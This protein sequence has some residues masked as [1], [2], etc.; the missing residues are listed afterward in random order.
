MRNPAI[1]IA[2]FVAFCGMVLVNF[3]IA[4]SVTA[5]ADWPSAVTNAL[6]GRAAALFV[7][8]AGL[9][10]SLAR[11]QPQRILKRAAFLFLLG[12]LNLT[13][14][15]AD[16]LHFYALY[17]LLAALLYR[18]S[19]RA[20]LG[21]TALIV[22][23]GYICLFVLD[24]S[25]NWDWDT[26]TYANFTNPYGFLRHS[27]LNGWHPVFPWAGFLT[28][29]MWLGRQDLASLQIQRRL[30]VWG[31]VAGVTAAL[32]QHL[33]HSAA[34]AELMGTAALPPTPFYM[35]S[36]T[37][38]AC[39][40]LGL[41]LLATPHFPTRISEALAVT[42]RQALTLYLAHIIV[43]M[44]LLEA[45]GL[46]D[47]TLSTGAIFAYSLGFCAA[48]VIY[49]KAWQRVLPYGPLEAVLKRL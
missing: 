48:C 49:A 46:L 34:L 43:G 45:F 40:C 4:A 15:E 12:L 16:I 3:R 11:A 31:A 33:V 1:D 19:D 7:L 42:G 24:Y 13:I 28:F 26:L 39:A 2:R 5:T 20:L 8:L 30:V 35:V 22:M 18:A 27:F 25:A 47:G 17:F 32:P 41:L 38:S 6:E 21:A 36:A 44:G 37:G 10:L 29:G 14:F 23:T 9:G